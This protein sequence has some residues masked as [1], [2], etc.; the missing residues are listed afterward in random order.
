MKYQRLAKVF[1]ICSTRALDVT[2]TK[3][4]DRDRKK[5][6]QSGTTRSKS[7][8]SVTSDCQPCL[9]KSKMGSQPSL[10]QADRGRG[11]CQHFSRNAVNQKGRQATV[12]SLQT[13]TRKSTWDQHE[14]ERTRPVGDKLFHRMQLPIANIQSDPSSITLSDPTVSGI[15]PP[16]SAQSLHKKPCM[17]GTRYHGVFRSWRKARMIRFN[18]PQDREVCQTPHSP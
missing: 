4:A 15:F 13:R 5:D 1:L 12:N 16:K 9:T 7:S 3:I 11:Q 6:W 2:P 14:S 18:Q 10:T 17:H 8:P